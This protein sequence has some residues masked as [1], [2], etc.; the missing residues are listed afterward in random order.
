[1]PK[2]VHKA[3]CGECPW[4]KE[5]PRGWLGGYSADWFTDRIRAEHPIACHMHIQDVDGSRTIEDELELI[6]DKPYCAGALI[7]QRNMLKLPRVRA[8]A[9]AVSS[10]E[11]SDTVFSYLKDFEEHHEF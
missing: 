4:R 1:M 9:E 2:L 8:L 7:V 10:V 6:A 11:K 3:P 5:S